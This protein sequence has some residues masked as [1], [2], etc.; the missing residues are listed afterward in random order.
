MEQLQMETSN[1]MPAWSQCAAYVIHNPGWPPMD[2]M[3]EI[4][5]QQQTEES[6]NESG[7]GY[8]TVTSSLFTFG[9]FS[10]STAFLQ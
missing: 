6:K 7:G 3:D 5:S 10:V 9:F 8:E 2:P 1:M 4:G